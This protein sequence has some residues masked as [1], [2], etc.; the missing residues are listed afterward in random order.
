MLSSIFQAN[1]TRDEERKEIDHPHQ[2]HQHLNHLSLA[3]VI[4]ELCGFVMGVGFMIAVAFLELG[5]EDKQ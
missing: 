5:D 1:R 2:H 4:L 3:Q